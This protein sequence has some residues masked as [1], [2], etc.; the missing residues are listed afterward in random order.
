MF[1]V[2]VLLVLM[3]S[4]FILSL[5]AKQIQF[6]NNLGF[7]FFILIL[8]SQVVFSFELL[9][10]FRLISKNSFFITNIAIFAVSLFVWLKRGRYCYIPNL[11]YEITRIYNSLKLDKLLMLVFGFFIVFF[12]S[13]LIVAVFFPV[14]YGDALGYYLS[15]CTSWIQ[16]GSIAHYITTDSREI[17]MPV[18]SELL[19]TWVLL[20]LKNEIGVSVFPFIF[21]INSIYVIYNFLGE[22]CFSRRKRLWSIFVFSS[23]A[24]VYVECAIPGA[25]LLIG[26]LMLTSVYIFFTACKYKKTNLLF[27]SSLSYALA[28]GTKTTSIIAF[29]VSFLILILIAYLYNKDNLKKYIG[30]YLAFLILN[31][32][33][34][35]SYNY[36]LNYIDYMNPV[37]DKQ[38]LLVNQFRGGIKGYLSNLIK[39]SFGMFDFSGIIDFCGM[40]NFIARMQDKV[41]ALIGADRLSYTSYFFGG[42]FAY[43][44]A[45]TI[46]DSLLGFMG[47]LTFYPCI[48]YSVVRAVKKKTSKRTVILA[49]LA[50]S[51]VLNI[52]IFSRVMVFTRFNM[53]YL[54]AF[55]VIASPILVYTY[56]KRN[57]NVYKLVLCWFLFIYLVFYSHAQPAIFIGAYMRYKALPEELKVKDRSFVLDDC[58]EFRIRNYF[59]SKERC[60]IGVMLY[61]THTSIYYIHKLRLNGFHI[62]NLLPEMIASYDLSKYKYIITLKG[63][64]ASTL[65]KNFNNNDVVYRR[66]YCAYKNFEGKIIKPEDN[67]IP[68]MVSCDVPDVYLNQNGFEKADDIYLKDYVLY[69]KINK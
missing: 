20:F 66:S 69:K 64:V 63:T 43:T 46:S 22:L 33:I 6:K 62:D 48:I 9:S 55:A 65:I 8:F 21:Y 16:N 18:N 2:S 36:I 26:S 60:N 57:M 7:I 27:F 53:R 14:K 10:L 45:L 54:L 25:D 29:P 15:R 42:F 23:L 41:L 31:F 34:F 49:A 1:L 51:Y 37:A 17:I 67:E 35:S 28:I 13:M 52:L 50:L 5:I 19:Y 68:V 30:L 32:M 4:Y 61:Q 39:Y 11:K 12:I 56:I 59:L 24:L 44:P 58:D 40:G 38:Q 47:L 3:S